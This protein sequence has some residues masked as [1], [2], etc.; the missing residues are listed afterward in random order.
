MKPNLSLYRVQENRTGR[1]FR[2]PYEVRKLMA[3]SVL[4]HN[5]LIGEDILEG[6]RF[7]KRGNVPESATHMDSAVA[8]SRCGVHSKFDRKR[9]PSRATKLPNMVP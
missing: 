9:V 5:Y 7:R 6:G 3:P 4:P 2:K 8:V 1:R